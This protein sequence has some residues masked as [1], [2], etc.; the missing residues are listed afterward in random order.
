[1]DYA[2]AMSELDRQRGRLEIAAA[3]RYGAMTAIGAAL[4]AA[5]KTDQQFPVTA[6]A[7]RVGLSR[8]TLYAAMENVPD[9]DSRDF[10][11]MS[12]YAL[13][14][15]HIAYGY[16]GHEAID[17][18]FWDRFPHLRGLHSAQR[19]LVEAHD[20]KI[21]AAGGDPLLDEDDSEIPGLITLAEGY[22]AAVDAIA[23]SRNQRRYHACLPAGPPASWRC[24]RQAGPSRSR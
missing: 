11:R 16:G 17:R 2:E 3:I 22:R 20:K 19:V 14:K 23:R 6:A 18:A 12:D 21:R 9:D 5:K 7:G 10:A 24:R 1:V 15:L 13:A 8:P 4:R